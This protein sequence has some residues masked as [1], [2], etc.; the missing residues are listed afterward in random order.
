MAINYNYKRP[1]AEVYQ[2]LSV[3][4]PVRSEY[5][6]ACVIG[7]QYD[8]YKYADGNLTPTAFKSAGDTISYNIK[9]NDLLDYKVDTDSVQLYGENLLAAVASNL[10]LKVSATNYCLL[11]SSADGKYLAASNAA[12]AEMASANG[13]SIQVGD[14][15]KSGDEKATVTNLVASESDPTKY[16]GII[17]SKC[18]VDLSEENLS[19]PI[20]VTVYKSFSGIIDHE[21][22]T[23]EGVTYGASLGITVHDV[24]GGDIAAPFAD[25]EGNLYTEYRAMVIYDQ[26]SAVL[27]LSSVSQIQEQL[28]T[29]DPNNELAYAAYCAFVGAQQSASV[30]AV[31]VSDLTAEAFTEALQKTEGN[32]QIYAVVPVSTDISIINAVIDHNATMSTPERKMW[33]IA[34][35][36]VS[37]QEKQE[38]S[39]TSK[40]TPITVNFVP[41]Y[42]NEA[43]EL[44]YVTLCQL[45][46]GTEDSFSFN[47]FTINGVQSKLS[48][49]DIIKT[50]AGDEYTVKQVLMDNLVKLVKGPTTTTES[51]TI[52]CIK[53]DTTDNNINYITSIADA[54]NN[55]RVCVVWGDNLKNVSGEVVATPFC[56][57]EVA[58]MTSY[59]EPQQGLT[60]MALS[61]VTSAP[62]MYTRYTQD[63]LDS[64]ARHG[65]LILAQDT[66]SDPVYI[67]H[68]LTTDAANGIL[69]RE[70]S[71]TRIIDYASYRV[72]DVMDQYI[73]KVNVVNSALAAIEQALIS[74]WIDLTSN[75]TSSLVGPTLVSYSDVRVVQSDVSADRVLAYVTYEIPAPLNNSQTYQ[76]CYVATG[77]EAETEEQ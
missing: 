54:I 1:S 69:Y 50:S 60:N 73:G 41:A 47:D 36:G 52:T 58:G 33:R 20:T 10:Q 37:S 11:T 74:T 6:S 56:A 68:Q 35:C 57:A 9:K 48:A 18:L 30:Y 53:Q 5:G 28:G 26:D 72:A 8:L 32:N 43:S 61:S 23:Q 55:R 16:T 25:G 40:G 22:A 7:A 12:K 34:V 3:E 27:E 19:T 70:L 21:S 4:E 45:T 38:V 71:C 75:A 46:S 15:V 42:Q 14:I 17:L 64:I 2:L 66:S 49:G 59:Y 44:G 63:Q 77:Q 62:R 67:R 65:V 76:M 24:E 39:T 13:Y 51:I 29:I 31:R